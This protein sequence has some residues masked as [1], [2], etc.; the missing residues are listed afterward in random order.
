MSIR[1]LIFV[2]IVAVGGCAARAKEGNPSFPVTLEEARADLARMAKG[3]RP[4]TRPIVVLG[5]FADPG[6]GA[7]VVGG[8]LRKYLPPDATVVCVSFTFC[9][10]FD[11]CRDRVIEAVDR[12][13]LSDD[14]QRT[15]EVDVVGLSMGGL[16]GRYSAAF[17]RSDGRRLRVHTLFTAASP[18][19][20][21]LR[22]E[23]F[24]QI[25]RM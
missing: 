1:S 11:A 8:E 10:S 20:G 14:P 22:A 12:A 6:V 9:N 25:L 19:T 3:P 13:A 17:A 2:V 15:A 7:W 23:Q 5:G 18:H 16:V 4:T 21:A 24:P